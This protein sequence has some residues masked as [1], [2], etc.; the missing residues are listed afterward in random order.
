MRNQKIEN[1][2]NTSEIEVLHIGEIEKANSQV[3]LL[4]EKDKYKFI[5][6]VEKLCRSSLEYKDYVK[7]LKDYID[8]TT[9]SYFTNLSSINMKKLKIEIHHEP[10]SLFDITN[11]VVNKYIIENLGLNYEQISEEVMHLHYTKK[12]GLIPL[13]ITVHELVHGGR[14]FIP[15]QAVRGDII[16]FVKEY[17]AYIP[18]DQKELLKDKIIMSKQIQVNGKQDLSILGKKFLYIE[19]DGMTFPQILEEPKKR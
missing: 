10:F 15:I 7:Y 17:D 12:I 16:G 3:V 14:L 4:S 1:Y 11:I 5:K 19:T 9:C 6:N 8:M 18:E 13:S 2:N